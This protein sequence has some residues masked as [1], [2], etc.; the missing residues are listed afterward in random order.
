MAKALK[1]VVFVAVSM[2]VA[3]QA[4]SQPPPLTFEVRAVQG[5]GTRGHGVASD[6]TIQPY[7]GPGVPAAIGLTLPIDLRGN[8][9]PDVLLCHAN[10]PP[11]PD[12]TAKAPCRILRPQPD[13]TVTDITR[14]LLGQGALPMVQHP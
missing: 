14:Q 12:P 1:C 10:Y 9:R 7:V 2:T 8:G 13:G 6:P 5:P 11:S 4:R 3:Y